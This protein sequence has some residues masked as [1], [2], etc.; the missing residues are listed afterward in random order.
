MEIFVSSF[1]YVLYC[2]V[3]WNVLKNHYFIKKTVYGMGIGILTTSL[4][5]YFLGISRTYWKLFFNTQSIYL[6]IFLKKKIF[7]LFGIKLAV[8]LV[9]IENV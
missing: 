4:V 6:I 5:R 2:E 8:S 9:N 1:L 3:R 7:D